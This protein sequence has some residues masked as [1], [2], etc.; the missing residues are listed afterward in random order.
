MLNLLAMVAVL[1]TGLYLAGLAALAFVSPHRAKRFLSSFASS[2]F[3]HFLELAVRLAAG[4]ALV[5]YAPR[6]KFPGLFAVAGWV[7]VATTIGLF[8]IPWQWHRRFALWSVPLATRNMALFGLGSLAAGIFVL[9]SVV[10]GPGLEHLR[11]AIAS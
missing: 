3:A 8:A 2:A 6:M 7:V 10:L 9:L 4:A 1:L 11:L 5:A